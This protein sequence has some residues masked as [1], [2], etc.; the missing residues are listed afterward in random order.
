MILALVALV[1]KFFFSSSLMIDD[2]VYLLGGWFTLYGRYVM[3]QEEELPEVKE[4]DIIQIKKITNHDKETQPPKRYTPSSIIKELEKKNL[5]TKATRASIIDTLFQRHYV[6]GSKSIEATELGIRTVN[7][8][9]E[10]CPRILD[11]E[12]TRHFEEEMDQIR[13][14]KKEKELVLD[15]A[16]DA[17]SKILDILKENEKVIGEQLK[18]AHI[19]TRDA[20]TTLGKCPSCKDGDLQIRKGKYGQFAA[21]NKYPDCK[22]TFSLPAGA[23][24]KPTK[25]TCEVCSFPMI[26]SIKKRK[27]PQELCLNP[28][29]ESKHPGD[30]EAEKPCPSCKEGTLILRKSLYGTFYGCNRYPKCKCTE[31]IEQKEE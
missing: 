18:S 8:L 2:G 16:K 9:E 24:L 26:L 11:E 22:T 20:L 7:T 5:G 30:V 12:M 4:K 31:Q 1:P 15:E 6:T 21:C 27:R 3:L 25:N 17:I 19:E 10:F 28:D 23:L 29:C 13:E 14:N